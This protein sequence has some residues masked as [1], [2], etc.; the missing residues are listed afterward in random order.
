MGA[1]S[2]RKGY[3]TEKRAREALEG[4]GYFVVESR[5]SHGPID[6][7]AIPLRRVSEATDGL[8]RLVQVKYGSGLKADDR[9]HLRQFARKLDSKR[10]IIELWVYPP[11]QSKPLLSQIEP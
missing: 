4:M 3:A 8:I 5:G 1:Q 7:V 6:L 9:L 2:Y 11:W 10:V